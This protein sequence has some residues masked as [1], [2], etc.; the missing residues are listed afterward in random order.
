MMGGG[1]EGLLKMYRFQVAA[2]SA[3][4]KLLIGME[5]DF[6]KCAHG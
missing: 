5:T 4:H 1:G 3:D 2:S 6:D